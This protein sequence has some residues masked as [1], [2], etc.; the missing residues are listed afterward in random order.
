MYLEIESQDPKTSISQDD[1]PHHTLHKM[2]PH[3]ALSH[4][5]ICAEEST[6]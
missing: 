6:L 2:L 1:K 5:V 3:L 4:L